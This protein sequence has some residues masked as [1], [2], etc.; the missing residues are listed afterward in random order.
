MHEIEEMQ[1]VSR[2][3]PC[4]QRSGSLISGVPPRS[5]AARKNRPV[6]SPCY[7][8]QDDCEALVG[9]KLRVRSRAQSQWACSEPYI[10]TLEK[11]SRIKLHSYN[12]RLLAEQQLTCCNLATLLSDPEAMR[13]TSL[14]SIA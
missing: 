9:L 6:E 2:R 5:L 13:M 12:E 7:F 3:G 1:V 4:Q 14:V 10:A 11:N 8:Y